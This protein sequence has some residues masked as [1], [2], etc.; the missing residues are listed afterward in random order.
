MALNLQDLAREYYRTNQTLEVC[1]ISTENTFADQLS[2]YGVR[3][4]TIGAR[5]G[6]DAAAF[7]RLCGF[8]RLN[9]F[10]VI[11]NHVATYFVVLALL[12]ASPKTAKVRQEHDVFR[13]RSKLRSLY[14]RV[15]SC[16]YDRFIAVS[17]RTAEDLVWAGVPADRVVTIPNP[18]DSVRFGASISREKAKRHLGL[19]VSVPVVGTAC[20]F[21]PEKDLGLF[22]EVASKIAA[23]GR[24]VVFL[25]V[26]SGS[27]ETAVKHRVDELNL[28]HLVLLTG[29]LADMPTV[30]RAMDIYLFTSR[31]ESFGRTILESL[32]C[33]TPVVAAVPYDGGAIDN[34]RQG[35]GVLS[36]EQRDPQRLADLVTRLLD[37][38]EERE[39][40]GRSGRLWAIGNFY[41]VCQWT[42]QF[43]QLYHSLR[44]AS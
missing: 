39:E 4:T 30:L 23:S 6:F 26:G 14:Y 28:K 40:L 5:S 27:E 16:A 36:D 3:V 1:I 21:A 12:L 15:F 44:P 22:L 29:P 37:S 13:S 24:S 11:H 31:A 32:A 43:Q 8:L 17:S 38:E 25:M 7:L 34:I 20:R 42:Q 18:I 35:C 9:A 19:S 33:E 10:D 2:Q 41:N